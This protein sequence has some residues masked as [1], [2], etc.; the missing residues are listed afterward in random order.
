MSR[1]IAIK[2]ELRDKAI[3]TECLEHLQCQ[4]LDDTRGIAMRGAQAPVH[5]LVHAPFG[6]LGFRKTTT[7]TYEV[8]GDD[9]ILEPHQDFLDQVTRQYAYRK[10]VR[11]A[12]NAGYNLVQEDVGADQTIKLV[13]RKW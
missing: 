6:T 7:D 4:V 11:D 13:V 1:F 3:L 5:L 9:R 10:I 12:K 8:V 2:T